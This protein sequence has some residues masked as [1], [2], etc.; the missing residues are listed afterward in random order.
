MK[1]FDPHCHMVTRTTDDY[2]RMALAGIR[3]VAEPSF[4]LGEPRKRAGTFLDY[5]DHLT[6]YERKRAAAYLIEHFCAISVN[7]RESNNA[8]VRDEVLREMPKWLSRESVVAVGE[9]GFDEITEAEAF[10]IERQFEMAREAGLPVIVHTPHVEKLKGTMRTIEIIRKLGFPREMVVLDHN[11]EET[12]DV[13]R[14]SGC[15]SGLTVYNVTKLSPERA[16]NIIEKHG[17]E[18]MLVNSSCD[19]GPSD[20]LNVPRTVL[21]LRRRGFKDDDIEKLCWKNP[22]AFY[23]PSGRMARV[24]SM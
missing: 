12:I 9:V 20:P 4:W 16:A 10:S 18:K 17:V 15:W 7:P 8:A 6:G 22:I 11:T 13:S 24:E 3:A 2:E 14:E 23:R 1:I 21:E 19:W 5:F